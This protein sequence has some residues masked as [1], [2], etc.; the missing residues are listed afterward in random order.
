MAFVAG[1]DLGARP[2]APSPSGAA[3]VEAAEA[4]LTGCGL[5]VVEG[6]G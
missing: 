5:L 3:A 1:D 2:E 4:F 6:S